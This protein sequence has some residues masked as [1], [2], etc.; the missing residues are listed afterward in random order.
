MSLASSLT[1]SHLASPSAPWLPLKASIANTTVPHCGRNQKIAI[2]NVKVFDGWNLLPPS[3]VIID[4]TVIGDDAS[5]VTARIDG[6][7]GVL[8]PGFIDSHAH[9][10]NNTDLEALTSYGVTTAFQMA[11]FTK[12]QCS[13]L[14]GQKGLV[15]L[16]RGTSP[17]AAPGS[18]HGD[19]IEKSASDPSL[20]V[21]GETDVSRWIEEQLAWEPDFF[22]LIVET[23]GL[24]QGTLNALVSQAHN[25]SRKV[26]CHAADAQSHAE[27]MESGTDQTHHTPLDKPITQ[28]LAQQV[29]ARGQVVVPTLTVMK[30]F[31]NNGK[32]RQYSF[33][34]ARESV[35]LYHE[36]HVPIMVG[37]DANHEIAST[38]DFGISVH[39]EL[40]LLAESGMS[41][42]EVLR[43]ATIVPARHWGLH[44]RGSIKP[45][46]RA[47]LVLVEGDP[48]N[49]IK[50]TRNIKRVWVAGT[51]HT[52]S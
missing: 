33:E 32:P 24:S 25:H 31:T 9:P 42:V 15:D 6:Q 34:A 22:K 52:K 23:P 10:R 20:L 49:N 26:V 41:N 47:D 11:C 21:Q 12:D 7:G 17:A 27:S 35:R 43:S 5:H 45:G 8:L 50:D 51:E 36:A 3:T 39:D 29:F 28:D 40:A 30:A 14:E 2:D 18:R 38:V 48:I 13:A 4:G 44:D 16:R 46:T 1:S 19:L 37:T